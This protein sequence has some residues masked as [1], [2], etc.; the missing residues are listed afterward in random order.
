[1]REAGAAAL[2]VL[3]ALAGNRLLLDRL[4]PQ[5]ISYVVPALE[6]L[7]KTGS[8]VLWGASIVEVH[9]LFGLAEWAWDQRRGGNRRVLAGL[10]GLATH[11]GYGFIT[12]L[13]V[14]TTGWIW[15]GYALAALAHTL[16]NTAVCRTAGRR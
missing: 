6:E 3:L 10:T 16:W 5:A 13:A 11:L 4:G 9:G 12:V 14:R 2:A 1:M 15:L 8:A 7:L